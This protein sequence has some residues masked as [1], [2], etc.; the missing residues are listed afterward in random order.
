MMDAT[1]LYDKEKDISYIICPKCGKR[2]ELTGVWEY[3]FYFKCK[4]GYYQE[5]K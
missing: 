2:A 3:N 4:C 1:V 5:V